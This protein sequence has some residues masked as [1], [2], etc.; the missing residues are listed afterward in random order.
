MAEAD[1]EERPDDI[2]QA[3]PGRDHTIVMRDT[4]HGSCQRAR[5]RRHGCGPKTS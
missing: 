1:P 4:R 5:N 3:E 2:P